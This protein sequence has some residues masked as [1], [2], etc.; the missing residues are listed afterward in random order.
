MNYLIQG[1]YA[2]LWGNELPDI[3]TKKRVNEVDN[4]CL[5]L[6]LNGLKIPWNYKLYHQETRLKG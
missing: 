5:A 3:T 4:V 2:I 1:I 6:F